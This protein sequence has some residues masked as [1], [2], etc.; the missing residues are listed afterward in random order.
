MQVC[1]LGL[2]VVPDDDIWAFVDGRAALGRSLRCWRQRC[3]SVLHTL[4]TYLKLRVDSHGVNWFKAFNDGPS[5]RTCPI[6]FETIAEPI[7]FKEIVTG[8]RNGEGRVC[9]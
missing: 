6:Y 8:M 5:R 4:Q 3:T 9:M 7:F 2:P 1:V